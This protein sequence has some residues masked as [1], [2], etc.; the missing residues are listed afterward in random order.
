MGDSYEPINDADHGLFEG[1]T[2]VTSLEDPESYINSPSVKHGIRLTAPVVLG[3]L[4]LGFVSVAILLYYSRR[5]EKKKK[6]EMEGAQDQRSQRFRDSVTS[7]AFLVPSDDSVETGLN[8]NTDPSVETGDG[9][10]SV[11]ASR[12]AEDPVFRSADC[13]L[14]SE[15]LG[16][17]HT[18]IYESNNAHCNHCFHAEC[19]DQW[20]KFQNTCPTCNQ[21]F[22][23]LSA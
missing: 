8:T 10:S 13:A 18:Q 3:F 1:G 5:H 23:I 12:D 7:K 21:P 4:L 11:L 15:P 16:Q 19:M 20:L 2:G 14:C 6:Q 22:A 9:R 17:D